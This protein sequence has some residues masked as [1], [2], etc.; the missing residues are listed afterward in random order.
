MSEFNDVT[1][2]VRCGERLVNRG[3]RFTPQRRQVYSLLLQARD[4]PT[5]NEVYLRAKQA[6][7]D[8]SMATVYNCLDALVQCGLV[9]QVHL[10]R[11]ATRFCLNMDKHSHFYCET[12]RHVYDIA[13][14]AEGI[15]SQLILPEGFVVTHHEVALRGICAT[16][17]ENNPVKRPATAPVEMTAGHWGGLH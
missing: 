6:L 8:L 10:D 9:R 16:C 15:E 17:S 11:E 1:N 4:H 14:Q 7:P 5:A 2:E 13:H 3:F 12:C